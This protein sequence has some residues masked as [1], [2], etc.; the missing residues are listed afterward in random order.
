MMAIL[1]DRV[2]IAKAVNATVIPL[3]S[4]PE[5]Y[6]EFDKGVARKFVIDPNGSLGRA[7]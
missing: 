2:K 4:A 1:H 7:A 3:D 6:A 5:G